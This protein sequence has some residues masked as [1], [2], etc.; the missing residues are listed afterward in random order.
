MTPEEFRRIGHQLIDWIADYRARVD[1][2]PVMSQ[3]EPGSIRARFS[4]TPPEVGESLDANFIDDLE[5]IILPGI[6][7]WNHPSFFAYF[8][9]NASLSAVLGDLL[10]TGLGAQG[11]SWQTSPAA[12]ELEEV[13]VDWLRQ[14]VGLSEDFVG[15][16]HDT[17]STANLVALLCARERI[18]NYAQTRSGLQAEQ[19]PLTVYTSSESHSSVEKAAL[20][21]GFGRVNVRA[22]E[23]DDEHAM[24][25]IA[26]ERAINFDI[27]RSLRPCAVVATIGTTP[28]TALDPLEKIA[29]IARAHALWLHVDAALAGA[30][31]ILP[32]CRSM[33]AGI[34]YADSLVWNPHKWLGAACDCSLYYVRDPEHLIR[35]MST[36]ASYLQTAADGQVNNFRDW[37][38]PL[39]R[40]FRALKLWLLIRSSGAEGL[41]DRLRR[42]FKNA[43]WLREQVDSTPNWER[44]APVPLQTVCVRHVPPSMTPDEV[45]AHTLDWVSRINRSGKA[46]L[47]PA[48]LKGRWMVRVSIGAEPTEHDHVEALWLLMQREAECR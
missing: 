32:E 14:L 9:S 1:E 20:L 25:A 46:F 4:A 29:K 40:R 36:N 35:V 21:A 41:R 37:G 19:A 6:T 12:T 38:I 33:W 5:R 45:D 24:D 26:L 27:E 8:P 30:A 28:T 47:T 13:V 17:A 7:H 3:V 39:G 31:M 15:V 43:Q 44:V 34:E 22:I 18:T 11:M 42:D 23:T 16:I 10:S 2:F 48:K